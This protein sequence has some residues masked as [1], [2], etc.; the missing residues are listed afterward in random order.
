MEIFGVT[1]QRSAVLITPSQKAQQTF[2]VQRENSSSSIGEDFHAVAVALDGTA[3]FATHS[4]AYRFDGEGMVRHYLS[5]EERAHSLNDVTIDSNGFVWFGS[6]HVGVFRL[7]PSTG[8]SEWFLEENGLPSDRWQNMMLAPDE[9][10]WFINNSHLSKID[11]IA[12]G[13][14]LEWDVY[15]DEEHAI[16]FVWLALGK[17]HH[18]SGWLYL[19]SWDYGRSS[20]HRPVFA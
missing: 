3:W 19:A 2:T 8:E 9:S 18:S 6:H 10:L 7:N 4:G 13:E 5:D 20:S 1:T 12:W 14:S 11:P 16:T 15:N 17:Q